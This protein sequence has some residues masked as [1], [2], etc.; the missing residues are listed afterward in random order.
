MGINPDVRESLV[1][2]SRGRAFLDGKL[3]LPAEALESFRDSIHFKPDNCEP[4]LGMAK[5]I[6]A[7]EGDDIQEAVVGMKKYFEL[8]PKNGTADAYATLGQVAGLNV[9]CDAAFEAVE[10]ALQLD[11]DFAQAYWDLGQVL[12][13]KGLHDKASD[14]YK[15]TDSW[16]QEHMPVVPELQ[17][18]GVEATQ[19][20]SKLP[21]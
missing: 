14:C 9:E 15:K 2:D 4:Y 6:L 3:K 7:I 13:R 20:L 18:F 10:K 8:N 12:I 11:P 19:L 5:A 16:M 1:A 21:H 17:R